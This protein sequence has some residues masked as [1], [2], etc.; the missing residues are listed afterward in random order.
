MTR[1]EKCIAGL[2]LAVNLGAGTTLLRR[3]GLQDLLDDAPRTQ[4]ASSLPV[5]SQPA[6]PQVA[7]TLPAPRPQG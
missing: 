6:E 3:A 4:E 1:R 5:A 2:V 7:P